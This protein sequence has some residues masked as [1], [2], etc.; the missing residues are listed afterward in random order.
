MKSSVD[1]K[2]FGL[3]K[4]DIAKMLSVSPHGKV[5][6]HRFIPLIFYSIDQA[7]ALKLRMHD[8]LFSTR[9]L[10]QGEFDLVTRTLRDLGFVNLIYTW[11]TDNSGL[12][13][14][15]MFDTFSDDT[16]ILVEVEVAIKNLPKEFKIV[17]GTSNIDR[18]RII[19]VRNKFWES[20]S[21]RPKGIYL[22]EDLI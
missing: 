8:G 21:E 2:K 10:D 15:V 1:L 16:G 18:D 3:V 6:L 20:D 5:F 19:V 22:I 11:C 7:N 4:D 17:T 14:M 9:S 12:N 13:D